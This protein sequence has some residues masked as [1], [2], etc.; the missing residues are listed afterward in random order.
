MIGTRGVRLGVVRPGL[1]E[2]Q[3]RALCTAA[4]SLFARGKRPCVEIMIP[5]VVE[6]EELRIARGWVREVLD[7]IGHP[8]LKSTVI[9]V[10]A[11]IETPRAALTAGE[12]AKHA[13]FFSFGTNDL[14][15][16]TY[17]F[18]R[19]DVEAK[20]LPGLPRARDPARQPVRRARPGGRRRAGADRLRRGP[21]GQ[22][23]H[24][25]RRLRRARR[26]PR[27]GRLPRAARPRL[28]QLLAV[29]GPARPPRRRPGAARQRTR[30]DQRHRVRPRPGAG[31][32]ERANWCCGHAHPTRSTS[33]RRSCCTRCAC[34]GSSP[35]TAS[36]RASAPTRPRSWPTLVEA[37]RGASHREARHVRPAATGQGAPGGAARHLRRRRRPGRTARR[38][39]SG[40]SSSTSMFKQLCTDWQMRG[41]TQNDHTDAAYDAALR[42]SAHAAQ[43]RRHV[44][45]SRAS[46]S[47]LPRMA[48][49]V[50]TARRGR[51]QGGGAAT[52][53]RSPA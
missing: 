46:P 9:T 5:L 49:Y 2:M 50:P 18:S 20:L 14:T 28:G 24:Q 53:R 30:Q 34:A 44:R 33:T 13:D 31:A 47:A 27:L 11:M 23:E 41:D 8:E 6:A 35:P 40:S 21:G 43:R 36:A 7:E 26:P 39:T 29:P 12:L 45:R 10:G 25:A 52:R 17:A 1:Y 3:V 15:Q 4:A 37:G 38:T 48:R 32:G 19:D 16:M 22:A 42:R 51:R